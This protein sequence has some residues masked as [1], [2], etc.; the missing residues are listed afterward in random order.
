MFESIT[1]HVE[2]AINRLPNQ[3]RLPKTE[4]VVRAIVGPT[5]DLET[6]LLQ[7]LTERAIDTAVGV[8]MDVIGRIV[9]E[10]RR[11]LND[12]T[13]RFRLKTRVLINRS[14]GTR[15]QL[16]QILV[17]ALLP[18]SVTVAVKN[19]YPAALT[20]E[21]FDFPADD[22]LT[23]ELFRYLRGG[24][25]AAVRVIFGSA[26][27]IEDEMLYCPKHVTTGN[28]LSIGS[29]ILISP[30]IRKDSFPESGAVLVD[31]G[32]A[33]EELLMYTSKSPAGFV[34]DVVTSFAH[35]NDYTIVF[36]DNIG[37]GLGDNGNP[38]TGGKLATGRA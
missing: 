7:L 31:Q 34:L 38:A 15:E 17:T 33:S 26:S 28:A 27:D 30:S 5:Q 8:Q 21:L 3:H 13:Y 35:T 9:G 37:K 29:S 4:A 18:S 12:D 25:A 11:G 23:D 14:E 19:E 16:I 6:A 20:V 22:V 2:I 24:T 36:D 10:L 32:T 1:N